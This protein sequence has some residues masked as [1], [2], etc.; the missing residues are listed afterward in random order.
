MLGAALAGRRLMQVA[1]GE[2]LFLSYGAL[3]NDFLLLDYGFIVEN[4]PHDTCQ[5]AF[6]MGLLEA[7]RSSPLSFPWPVSPRP[8][9]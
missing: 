7:G 9:P 6:D 8:C 5:L 1:A 3:G 2:E 4:N